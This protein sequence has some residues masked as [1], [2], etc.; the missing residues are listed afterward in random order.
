MPRRARANVSNSK[1][2]TGASLGITQFDFESLQRPGIIL[3]KFV[4]G[5]FGSPH[6]RLFV[7]SNDLRYLSW[8]SGWFCKK[9]GKTCVVPLEKVLQ[10][11]PGQTTSQ[12]QRWSSIYG[13]AKDTSFSIIY[14]DGSGNEKTLSVTAPTYDIYNLLFNGLQEVVQKLKDLT[15]SYSQDTIYMKSLWDR[16]DSDHSGTLV[17]SEIVQVLVSANIKIPF[18]TVKKLM[19]IVDKDHS[20]CLD[21]KEGDL[22]CLWTMIVDATPCCPATERLPIP[23]DAHSDTDAM[24]EG[25]ECSRDQVVDADRFASYWYTNITEAS[26]HNT[27]LEG[28]Q[29][30]SNSSV[31]RYISD[32]RLGCSKIIFK[33]V[34]EAIMKYAF[35]NSPYPV[36]L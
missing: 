5:Y 9:R 15:A 34:I 8:E 14:S 27:Y 20:E 29:L 28:D 7:L 31:N 17:L 33:D 1:S 25:R 23:E 2:A 30:T 26:S 13:E 32:L 10:F 12:F 35:E 24:E 4:G 18:A 3:L 22:E 6:E 36:V 16:A 19:K 11:F 21:F